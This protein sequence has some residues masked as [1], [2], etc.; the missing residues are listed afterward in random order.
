MLT[1]D[2][3][4][5]SRGRPA[6]VLLV[7][8]RHPPF[9]GGWA[10]PGGFVEDREPTREAASRELE[11]ETGVVAGPL[12]LVGVYDRPGRDP[13]GWTVS[14]AYRAE[15]E[16]EPPVAAADDARDARWFPVDD[17]PTLAFDH[18]TIIADAVSGAPTRQTPA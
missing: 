16:R 11:E 5:L 9:Q 13:R 7:Q 4:A 1:A 15:F 10:L 2:V 14:V 6:T 3:V 18:G 8:R 12:Q 17:L